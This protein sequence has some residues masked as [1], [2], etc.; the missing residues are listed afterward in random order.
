MSKSITDNFK[1]LGLPL[2]NQRW[3]WG[4]SNDDVVVLRVWK[5][6]TRKGPHGIITTLLWHRERWKDDNGAIERKKHIA[7][8]EAGK[9][10][11][12]IV[13]R[14]E[15]LDNDKPRKIAPS[16]NRP[17]F[18][19]GSFLNEGHEIRIEL[20]KRFKDLADLKSSLDA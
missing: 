2:V 20:V 6:H 15:N 19:C 8:I 17:V 11:F 1:Y 18:L 5:D 16:R 10:C 9:T 13:C 14:D 4:A 7:E 12:V 3:S